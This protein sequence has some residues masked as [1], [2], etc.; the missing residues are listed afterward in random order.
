MLRL[1]SR[2]Q[3][4]RFLREKIIGWNPLPVLVLRLLAAALWRRLLFRTTVV[5]ITGSVGKTT[6]KEMIAA[7]LA[8]QGRVRKTYKN[9]NGRIGVAHTLLQTTP[10]HRFC[11]VE[12]GID[13]PGLMKWLARVAK[14]DV[15]VWLGV[16][17]TH[18]NRLASLDQTAFE[19]SRLFQALPPGAF[20]LTPDSNPFR[21]QFPA[22]QHARPLLFGQSPEA[23]VRAANI[24]CAWPQTLS[25]DLLLP[26]HPPLPVQTQLAA[27]HFLDAVLS[28]C[29]VAHA[30]NIPPAAVAEAIRSVA[31]FPAR[32]SIHSTPGGATFLRDDYNGSFDT[33]QPGLDVV[34]RASATRKILVISDLSDHSHI[35]TRGKA[36]GQAAAAHFDLAVFIGLKTVYAETAATKAG[37]PPSQIRSFFSVEDAARFLQTE[38]RPGDFVYLKGRSTDHVSRVFL[39]LVQSVTCWKDR[40]PKT[41]LCDECPELSIVHVQ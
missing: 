29:A 16:A 13:R 7:V 36:I 26:N 14:P 22:P 41:C 21:L 38:L 27:P 19:K 40:C 8:T 2:R 34:A 24:S 35:R 5:A 31:P 37:L 33:F 15:A 11:V 32:C 4:S 25:F 9:L 28:A 39:H 10:F 12:I 18:T 1:P 23:E 20:A 3:L 6:A 17:R 30:L